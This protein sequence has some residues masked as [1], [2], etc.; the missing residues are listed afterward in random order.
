MKNNISKKNS[1]KIILSS[2]TSKLGNAVFDY[3][4]Q[5]LITSM[6]PKTPIFLS[7]YLSTEQIITV[8]L[9]LFAGALADKSIRKKLLIITDLF[10]G[11]ICL[12][13]LFF[14]NTSFVY[15]VIIISN[16]LLA[17]LFAFNSPIYNAIIKESISEEYTDK[18]YARY[19]MFRQSIDIIAPT[20]GI[21]I[22]N[23]LGIKY[24][25]LFNGVTFLF[26]AYISHKIVI[27]NKLEIKDKSRNILK[28]ILEGIKYV[29]KHKFLRRIVI[30]SS[31]LN[32]FLSAFNVT[33]PYLSA[34]YEKEIKDFYGKGLIAM[35]LGAIVIP[36]IYN[37]ISEKREVNNKLIMEIMLLLEGILLFLVFILGTKFVYISLFLFLLFG[38]FL[39]LF[40]VQFFTLVQKTTENEFIGRVFSVIFTV[41][42]LFMPISNI[43]FGYIVTSTS[44][45]GLLIGGVGLILSVFVYKVI[46]I[47]D[48]RD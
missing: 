23:F 47:T 42:V 12:I 7:L 2:V 1:N 33:L 17:I 14:V 21:F 32:I 22:W 9:N 15:F 36:Y 20:V 5:T 18:H 30:L 35:A 29:W 4:N 8:L 27:I 11:I 46:N 43:I 26:S 24:S 48:K 44:L 31:F 34:Y 28:D 16:G 45:I 37:K 6:F 10:S 3:C 38:G 41:A 13:G 39:S 40:N 25:Y 19:T